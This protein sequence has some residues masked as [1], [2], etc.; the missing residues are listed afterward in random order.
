MLPLPNYLTRSL[1]RSTPDRTSR[2]TSQLQSRPWREIPVPAREWAK[3]RDATWIPPWTVQEL[4]VSSS[5]Q[6]N[7]IS[8]DAPRIASLSIHHLRKEV[9]WQRTCCVARCLAQCLRTCQN[10]PPSLRSVLDH[11]CTAVRP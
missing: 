2:A 6:S 1:A 5:A 3:L 8:R 11:S 9:N 7:P 4:P 10:I